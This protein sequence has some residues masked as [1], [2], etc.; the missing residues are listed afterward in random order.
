[1]PSC[2]SGIN[3]TEFVDIFPTLTDLA[4]LTLPEGLAGK[5]LVPMLKN[6]KAEVKSYAQSQFVSL[7]ILAIHKRQYGSTH[8]VHNKMET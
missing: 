3:S 5:S 2:I 1:M 8:V 6:P 4:G 7:D